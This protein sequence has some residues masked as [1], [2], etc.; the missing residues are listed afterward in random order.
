M[1]VRMTQ[2]THKVATVMGFAALA[3]VLIFCIADY[4]TVFPSHLKGGALY[5]AAVRHYA[6]KVFFE[7][8]I[9]IAIAATVCIYHSLIFDRI[10]IMAARTAWAI[11]IVSVIA[12]AGLI[13][14]YA[15]MFLVMMRTI[16]PH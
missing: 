5:D 1:L 10:R 6:T 15:V 16:G 7:N 11:S 9:S 2:P 8:Y 13:L 12:S 14:L 3:V 4:F